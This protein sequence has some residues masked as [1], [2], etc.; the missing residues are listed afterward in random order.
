MLI[1]ARIVF[2]K[3]IFLLTYKHHLLFTG[4]CPK[5]IDFEDKTQ[6]CNDRRFSRRAYV[7]RR[8]GSMSCRAPFNDRRHV[9]F[10]D[11][12]FFSGSTTLGGPATGGC[13]GQ[14]RRS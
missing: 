6:L 4:H 8:T 9:D 3:M 10:L 1:V 11:R 14:S 5:E 7:A 13:V 2:L 12:W